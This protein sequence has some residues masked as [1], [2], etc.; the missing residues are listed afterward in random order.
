[1][2]KLLLVAGFLGLSV[3]WACHLNE[4]AVEDRFDLV[5]DTSWTACDN[6][7][8][9]LL[10]KDKQVIDTLFNGP[11][12]STDQLKSLSAGKY[13]GT[14]ATIHV[15]GTKAGGVCFDETRSFE[16]NGDKVVVDTISKPNAAPVSVGTEPETITMPLGSAGV[17]VV[18]FIKPTYADQSVDWSL[19]GDGIVSLTLPTGG[20]GTQVKVNPEMVG[21]TDITVRS[22]KDNTKSAKL[23]V[24]V[25]APNGNVVTVNHDSI[26]VYLGGRSESLKATVSPS[27]SDQRVEWRSLNP[28]VAAIDT[29]GAVTGVSVGETYVQAKSIANGVFVATHVDVRRDAPKL[30]V[31]SKTGAPVN[32]AITFSPHASQE[33]GS[34]VMYKWDLDGDGAYDDSTHDT[35]PGT[36]VDLPA[37]TA[38]YKKE[39][40]VTARFYVRDT[41]GN[42][43]ITGV[44]LDIGNQAP[45]V[46][47]ISHDT[48]VSILDSVPFKATVHDVDGKVAWLGWDYEND[49]V[50]DDSTAPNDTLAK[51][52]TYRKYPDAGIYRAILKAKDETGKVRLDTVLVKVDLDRPVASAGNDT[53]VT[54]GATVLVHVGGSDKYG[55]IVTREVKLPGTD[56]TIH[57]LSKG[58]TDTSFTASTTPGTYM[59]YVR[60]TDDDG[61]RNVD[62]MVV[63]VVLSANADLSNLTFSAGALDPAFKGNISNFTAHVA[64]P[65]SMVTVTPT[66]KDADA[67]ITVNAKS[68]ASGTASEAVKLTVGSNNKV[69][70]IIVTAADGTQHIYYV[71]VARD[72]SANASLSKLDVT[73][74]TLKPAFA[75]GVLDYADTVASSVASVTLKPTLAVLTSSLT[76]NDSG[77]AS[78]TATYPMPL[79]IGENIYKIVVTS[80][81]GL[82]K[83]TY[84]VKVIRKAQFFLFRSLDG[85]AGTQID[86]TESLPNALITLTTTPVTGYRFVKWTLL[87][88]TAVITDTA[89]IPTTIT[90]N[91]VK[92]KAQA[93]F[94]LNT[95]VSKPAATW[96]V[97]S[98]L[99]A[100]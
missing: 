4:A 53:T 5:G 64:F 1:M 26:V 17:A 80:Q 40:T 15:F 67:K 55:S 39:G 6:V 60:V 16:G 97:P 28:A 76:V 7:I 99:R 83:T 48:A 2:R 45:E 74:F 57:P 31:A 82:I 89:S 54:V 88:G 38:T 72:P 46:L 21:S 84:T 52:A 77:M 95:Y 20:N 78:G 44:P 29:A 100:T 75:S 93:N 71:S 65:D 30:T 37:Q 98:P 33:Y 79:A 66:A 90:L 36:Q 10:N 59:V 63:T 69:F 11:L 94:V 56:T 91:S 61:L 62:S 23:R 49:G 32:T 14:K 8:V 12:T 58:K 41:E 9:E 13:D 25:T 22:R 35:F 92:V 27:G 42:E 70:E 19:A 81:S 43:T 73:G 85:K 50:F 87:E 86:S 51:I 68:V 47:A 24:T 3:F 18:A 34:I 96:A